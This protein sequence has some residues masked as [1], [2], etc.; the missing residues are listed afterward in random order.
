MTESQK[1][2]L[3]EMFQASAYPGKGEMCLVARS[4]STS[5]ARIKQWLIRIRTMKRLEG[6][7]HEGEHK[8]QLN[9]Q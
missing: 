5:K 3:M 7:L 2:V 4:I 1:Q 8:L 9:T 6:E